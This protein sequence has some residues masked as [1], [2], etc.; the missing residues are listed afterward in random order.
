M[1][2]SK[3]L[4][5]RFWTLCFVKMHGPHR[6]SKRWIGTKKYVTESYHWN[7]LQ[8]KPKTEKLHEK[9]QITESVIH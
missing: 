9:L 2:I 1:V 8:L 7:Q 5:A 6:K 4:Q 3:H